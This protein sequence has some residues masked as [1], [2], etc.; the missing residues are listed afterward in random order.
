MERKERHEK[1]NGRNKEKSDGKER[2]EMRRK[3]AVGKEEG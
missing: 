2:H 1:E 3:E